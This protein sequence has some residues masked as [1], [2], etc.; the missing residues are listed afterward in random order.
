MTNRIAKIIGYGLLIG[1]ILQYAFSIPF[2]WLHELQGEQSYRRWSGLLLIVYIL[3]QW[4]LTLVRIRNPHGETSNRLLKIHQWSGA[5]MPLFFY[6]HAHALGFGYLMIL[7]ITFFVTFFLG[8]LN[9]TVIRSW[10]PVAFRCWYVTHILGT[11]VIT[12]LSFLHIWVVFY[13]K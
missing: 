7:A 3:S 1:Y 11:V 6:L 9:T 2:T 12:V 5:L 8:L 10:G 4:I 13:Y